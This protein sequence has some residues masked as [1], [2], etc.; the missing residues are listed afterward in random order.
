METSLAADVFDDYDECAAAAAD[1][2]CAAAAV[3]SLLTLADRTTAS[4]DPGMLRGVVRCMLDVDEKY[5]CPEGS[6]APAPSR[7]FARRFP[8]A[9]LLVVGCG[10]GAPSLAGCALPPPA[11]PSNA[12]Q[13]GS[14]AATAH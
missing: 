14:A 3:L 13:S 1:D 11:I 4:P 12:S 2:A 6:S 7:V 5:R 9:P 10:A 8:L